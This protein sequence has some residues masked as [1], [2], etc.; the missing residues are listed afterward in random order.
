[1]CM[2][3]RKNKLITPRETQNGACFKCQAKVDRAIRKMGWK[4]RPEKIL[5]KLEY[6]GKHRVTSSYVP[7]RTGKWRNLYEVSIL[8]VEERLCRLD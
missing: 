2:H 3:C 6:T 7:G 4:P 8:N 1:M 5:T